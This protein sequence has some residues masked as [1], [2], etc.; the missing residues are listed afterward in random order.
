MSQR[1]N[2]RH[3]LPTDVQAIADITAAAFLSAPHSSH[4]EQFIVYSL[5]QSGA[6][7]LSLVGVTGSQ[8]VGHIAFSPVTVADG[9]RDWY[10]L[11]PVS[12]MPLFQ[13]RGIGQ[14]L[15][16]SG[17]EILRA[18]GARGCV[19]L[20][21]PDYYRRFGFVATSDLTFPG[22][23]PEYFMSLRFAGSQPRGEVVYR[24]AF[25]ARA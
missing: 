23:P 4:T 8:L 5:R 1:F 19:V 10:G 7:S 2:L 9:S 16:Q 22:A 14:A 17:L 13:R 3:E 20:G 15:V 21:A 12:V 25:Y 6:L 11:G 18:R 24:D